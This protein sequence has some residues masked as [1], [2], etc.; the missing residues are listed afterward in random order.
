MEGRW[1]FPA[2]SVG[3]ILDNC[4]CVTEKADLRMS[5]SRKRLRGGGGTHIWVRMSESVTI[6]QDL[7]D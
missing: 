4:I 6:D 3:D 2:E 7:R 5:H 1:H